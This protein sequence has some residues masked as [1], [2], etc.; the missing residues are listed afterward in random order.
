LVTLRVATGD[1]AIV[2]ASEDRLNEAELPDAPFQGV[3]LLV[4]DPSR[5]PWIRT[6]LVDRDLLDG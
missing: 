5:V 6:Q 3:K 1:D 2:P 4:A